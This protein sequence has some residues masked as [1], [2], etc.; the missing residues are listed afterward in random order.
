MVFLIYIG[1]LY[2]WGSWL[3]RSILLFQTFALYTLLN[4][5]LSIE[6]LMVTSITIEWIKLW[7]T[8][9]SLRLLDFCCISLLLL[10]SPFVH[11]NWAKGQCTRDCGV[12]LTPPLFSPLFSV[13]LAYVLLGCYFTM[14]ISAESVF[15]SSI[16]HWYTLMYQ[17]SK[18]H[19]SWFSL[20]WQFELTCSYS[21]AEVYRLSWV[22]ESWG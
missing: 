22:G 17:K 11:R 14:I 3:S 2:W 21:G 9:L 4:Y 15:F 1:S 6:Y 16:D 19:Y 7:S 13:T 10:L 18:N 20:N 5:V 12:T 8:W